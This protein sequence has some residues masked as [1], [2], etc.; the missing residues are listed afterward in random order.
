MTQPQPCRW[1]NLDDT[2]L[3]DVAGGTS[4]A[5][6]A[7][8]APDADEEAQT[9]ASLSGPVVASGRVATSDQVST[10]IVVNGVAPQAGAEWDAAAGCQV[11]DAGA[12]GTVDAQAVAGAAADADV[13]AQAR[14]MI[15][16]QAAIAEARQG[17]EAA[18][19]VA[20]EAR[21]TAAAAIRRLEELEDR[22]ETTQRLVTPLGRAMAGNLKVQIDRA[23]GAA[24]RALANLAAAAAEFR[25]MG[26]TLR[27]AEATHQ[28]LASGASDAVMQAVERIIAADRT[29]AAA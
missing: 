26:A 11:T 10:S 22:A 21:A 5:T 25:D 4:P 2:A 29:A 14:G 27:N 12:S 18:A 16:A 20:E 7:G 19:A 24:H 3:A 1:T 9:G 28:A 17:F 6:G 23:E 15:V 13:I 8:T